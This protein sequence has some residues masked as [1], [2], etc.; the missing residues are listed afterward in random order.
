MVKEKM[1]L[2]GISCLLLLF[3]CKKDDEKNLQ[4]Q[5]SGK[6]KIEKT[7]VKVYENGKLTIDETENVFSDEDYYDFKPDGT[8]GIYADGE[9]ENATYSVN[10]EGNRVTITAEGETLEFDVTRLDESKLYLLYDD[11]RTE[12]GVELRVTIDLN[13]TK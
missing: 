10:E 8:I 7:T 3:S 9:I 5:I 13:L 2:L 1:Y 6:W 12:N 11:T 4:A